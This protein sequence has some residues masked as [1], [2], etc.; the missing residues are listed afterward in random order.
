MFVKRINS[1]AKLS[2][3]FICQISKF[4]DIISYQLL[5]LKG[6]IMLRRIIQADIHG[7][8]LHEAELHKVESY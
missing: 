7:D 3:P 5:F 2:W 8:E 4:M 6:L 1:R